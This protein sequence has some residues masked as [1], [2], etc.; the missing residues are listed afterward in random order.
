MYLIEIVDSGRQGMVV[1]LFSN[2]VPDVVPIDE[3]Q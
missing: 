1:E 3:D 2:V